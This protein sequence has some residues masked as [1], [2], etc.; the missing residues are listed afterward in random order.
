MLRPPLL[1]SAPGTS[2]YGYMS[3]DPLFFVAIAAFGWGL[4]LAIYR[5][6]AERLGW[7]KGE[8]QLHYPLVAAAVGAL[9]MASG[10]LHAMGET[11]E[12]GLAT[13]VVAGVMFA[14]FWTGFMR[15]ASQAGLLLAPLASAVLVLGWL[16][17]AL[18]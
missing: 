18:S 6:L 5:I 1:R 16:L 10:V 8:A 9:A 14:V 2:T 11:A 13:L 3:I 15:V 7:P 12:T 17:R 4:N